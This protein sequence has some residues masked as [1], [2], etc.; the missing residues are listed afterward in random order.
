[1]RLASRAD[2]NQREIVQALRTCGAAV[3]H[4]HR[5][6]SGCPDLLVCYHKQLFLIEIKT[7]TGRFTKDE[8]HF[9]ASWPGTIYVVRSIEEALEAINAI[10]YNIDNS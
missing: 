3:L 4:L 5:V 2:S 9:I 1:M 8:L 10:G 6:G 7:R